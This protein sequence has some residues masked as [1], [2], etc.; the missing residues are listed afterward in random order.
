M[1]KEKK[2]PGDKGDK[3][4]DKGGKGMLVPALIL[5]AAVL[6]AGYMMGGKGGHGPAAS[7]AASTTSTTSALHEGEVVK[8]D[9]ITLNLAD[10]RYLKVGLA[11]QLAEGANA[12]KLTAH[13]PLALD[14]AISLLGERTFAQLSAPGGRAQAKEE[15]TKRVKERFGGKVVDVYFT[16]FVMQ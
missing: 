1:A 9:S 6:G 10:N 12:E 13:A 8:L 11:L 4:K 5:A 14:E 16:E 2:E 3:G 7:A 15:L